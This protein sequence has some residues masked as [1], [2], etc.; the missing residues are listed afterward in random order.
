MILVVNECC[1]YCG[2]SIP[3]GNEAVT[4]DSAYYEESYFCSEDCRRM[5][6]KFDYDEGL[7]VPEEWDEYYSPDD[8]GP[9]E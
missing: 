5:Q 8:D 4:D 7:Y 1:M 3:A 6:K 9:Q 2:T